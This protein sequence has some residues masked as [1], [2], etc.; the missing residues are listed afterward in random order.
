MLMRAI[1]L[2]AN[3]QPLQARELADPEPGE[4]EVVVDVQRAGICHSDAHYRGEAGRTALP[5]TLGHEVAGVVSA[6]GANVSGLKEGDR[7]AL[8]YLVSCGTCERCRRHGEQF[9]ATGA[10]LGK[11]RDGGYAEKIAVP[12]INAVPVPDQV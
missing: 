3:R 9:C 1:R 4:G 2:L 10:M 8:H 11:E 12:A 7:V 6:V 5:V